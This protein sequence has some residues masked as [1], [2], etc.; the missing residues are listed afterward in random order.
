MFVQEKSKVKQFSS[1]YV[2][3][4]FFKGVKFYVKPDFN[5]ALKFYFAEEKLRGL[6]LYEYMDVA[7]IYAMG[8]YGIEKNEAKSEEVLTNSNGFWTELN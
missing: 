6:G 5:K 1:T 4:L 8:G 3:Y 7:M 2:A